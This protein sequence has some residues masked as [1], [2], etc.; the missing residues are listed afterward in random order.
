MR[1]EYIW[2]I[3]ILFVGLFLFA[4]NKPA[5]IEVNEVDKED[6]IEEIVSEENEKDELKEIASSVSR[7]SVV[8][9]YLGKPSVLVF[10]STS[11]PHC[12]QAMP[13]FESEIWDKYK[14]DVSVFLNVL[15]QKEFPETKIPQGYDPDMN[16]EI[17]TGEE[18]G[19]VPSWVVLNS[20]GEVKSASCGVEKGMEVIIVSLN[21]LLVE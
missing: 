16:F 19:V 2:L 9:K 5:D 7:D 21:E 17:L 18:C 3:V 13:L 8:E 14:E 15:D 4:F 1:K 12:Q 10:S 20:D 11:C 6:S